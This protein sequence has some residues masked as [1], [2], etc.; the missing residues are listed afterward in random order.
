[1]T[2]QALVEEGVVSVK[3]VEDAAI[4][5]HDLFEEE[6]GLLHHGLAQGFIEIGKQFGVGSDVLE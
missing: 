2:G 5:T 6:P 4:R 3:E 1:M